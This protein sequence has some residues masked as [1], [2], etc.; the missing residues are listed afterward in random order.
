MTFECIEFDLNLEI[1]SFQAFK[2]LGII[3]NVSL[4]PFKSSYINTFRSLEYLNI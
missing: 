4:T 3:S 1:T 2:K